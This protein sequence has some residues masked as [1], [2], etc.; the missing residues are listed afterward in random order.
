MNRTLKEATVKRFYYEAH[1]QLCEHLANFVADY[2][3]AKTLDGLTPYEHICR[4]WTKEPS[5]SHQSR[6]IE[7]GDQTSKP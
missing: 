1:G 5:G 6:T 7:L 3:F 4:I 2:N